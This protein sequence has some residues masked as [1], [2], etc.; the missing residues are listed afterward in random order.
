MWTMAPDIT[1][2]E[3]F[4]VDRVPVAQPGQ[5]LNPVTNR[6]RTRDD[7]WIQLVFLQPDRFWA[8]FVRRIG[9]PE[10]AEDERFVPSANLI[11]N[12]AEA[13]SLLTARFA[14]E[15]LSYWTKI[16]ADEK[17]VWSVIASPLEVLDDPQV[18][19]NDYLIGNADDAGKGYRIVAAPVQ[20]D[21]TAPAPARSPE[22]GE[23][24][25]L[26]L[27]ELGYDWDQITAAKESGAVL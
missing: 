1:A 8:D 2:A 25:E 4:G 20:Y 26:I 13:V 18:G 23:H 6:Y 5:A 19:G 17:G 15:D 24:T 3:F 22:H 14:E 10:L 12:S 21:E 7:R 9:C 27:L 16:L 11:A